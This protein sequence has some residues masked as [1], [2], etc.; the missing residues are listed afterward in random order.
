MRAHVV[1]GISIIMVVLLSSPSEAGFLGGDASRSP[2]Q[3]LKTLFAEFWDDELRAD[4]RAVDETIALM[5]RG[6][7]QKRVPPRITMAKVV[8]QL[9]ALAPE[10]AEAS[11]LWGII[12][13]LPKDWSESDRARA[14]AEVREAIGGSVIPA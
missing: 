10:S 5:K 14:A 11:P 2:G 4:P 6:V 7:V 12:A 3:Q 9:R 13:R 1:A 8:P